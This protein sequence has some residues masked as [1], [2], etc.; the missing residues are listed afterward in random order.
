M[1]EK[2]DDLLEMKFGEVLE[3]YGVLWNY[4]CAYPYGICSNELVERMYDEYN[5][6]EYWEAM[7]VE[8]IINSELCFCDELITW[9][10]IER[11]MDNL[12][13]SKKNEQV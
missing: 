9:E 1:S 10:K 7:T 4:E 2:F 12:G 3:K 6:D 8:M 11:I 13:I 5:V